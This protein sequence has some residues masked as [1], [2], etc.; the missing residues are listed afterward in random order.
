M[1]SSG[2]SSRLSGAGAQSKAGRL[3]DALSFRW[4]IFVFF[5]P[6][7]NASVQKAVTVLMVDYS[8]AIKLSTLAVGVV[9]DEAANFGMTA[10]KGGKYS[11]SSLKGRSHCLDK[12]GTFGPAVPHVESVI[13]LTT[14]PKICFK[15]RRLYRAEE[16]FPQA[17]P[18]NVSRG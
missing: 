14:A 12:T 9:M 18:R 10:R 5:Y 6:R 7:H 1:A 4:I 8:C 13:S 11:R 3:S 17:A 2:W 15:T 16:H